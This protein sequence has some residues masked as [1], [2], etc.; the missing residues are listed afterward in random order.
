MAKPTAAPRQEIALLLAF[1][2]GYVDTL[3]FVG[4]FGLF[5]THVTGN[6]VV[7]GAMIAH[8][9]TGLIAKLLAL[10]VF[11]VSVA[12][13]TLFV[14]RWRRAGRDPMPAVLATQGLLL[15]A[16]MAVAV[17]SGPLTAGDQ[18]MAILA[19]ELGVLAMAI[20]NASGRLVFSDLP[21]TAVM[22]SN[23]TQIVI[24]AVDLLEGA[25]VNRAVRARLL[26]PLWP[27]IAFAAGALGGGLSFAAVGFWGLV[28]P[29]IAVLAVIPL[30]PKVH[31]AG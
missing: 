2:A 21:P 17:A 16:F 27:I 29:I 1:T 3:G 20:Q 30:L 10:P 26:E 7:M 23:V 11:I 8:P 31:V 14:R 13:T 18:P 24:D 25:G 6:F 15:A 5:T 4:L 12:L 22:T 19:G 28:A 9:R